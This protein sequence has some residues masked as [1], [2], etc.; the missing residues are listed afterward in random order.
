MKNEASDRADSHVYRFPP[1]WK[2]ATFMV[3]TT[4]FTFTVAEWAP[5]ALVNK[6]FTSRE[7]KH[8]L[9]CFLQIAKVLLVQ[10]N[11]LSRTPQQV[12]SDEGPIV[13]EAS[14]V[15]DRR[16]DSSDERHNNGL[17]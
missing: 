17:C 15:H 13:D 14:T 6:R 9:I 11:H 2:L 8:R 12:Y 4:G 1:S 7:K 16:R 5:F 10:G 3:A